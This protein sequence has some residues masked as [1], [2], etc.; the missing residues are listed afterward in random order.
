MGS[1]HRFFYRRRPIDLGPPEP[2]HALEYVNIPRSIGLVLSHK[3]ATLHEMQT[4]Y[5]LEDVYD[6][7]EIIAVDAYNRRR[8]NGDR[9]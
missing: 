8:T 1:A 5:S 2:N 4:V 7:I 3:M 6:L 9:D